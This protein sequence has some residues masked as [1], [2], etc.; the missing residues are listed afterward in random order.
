MIKHLQLSELNLIQ[1]AAQAMSVPQ[2]N[3]EVVVTEQ[4]A[5]NRLLNGALEVARTVSHAALISSVAGLTWNGCC[6]LLGSDAVIANSKTFGKALLTS[7][8]ASCLLGDAH[9]GI[10]RL[11]FFT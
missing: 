5:F 6:S 9:R 4:G 3:S 2:A 8:G 11:M 7:I 10:E 1:G